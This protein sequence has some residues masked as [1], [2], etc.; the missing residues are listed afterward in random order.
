LTFA[1]HSSCCILPRRLYRFT[2]PL[3]CSFSNPSSSAIS[4][5]VIPASRIA[6][7]CVSIN[8]ICVYFL[9]DITLPPDVIILHQGAFCLLSDFTGSVH[10]PGGFFQASYH[11]IFSIFQVSLPVT[12]SLTFIPKICYTAI[13]KRDH[14]TEHG[15][16]DPPLFLSILFY[17]LNCNNTGISIAKSG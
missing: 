17:R 13:T 14:L 6:I 5:R 12:K 2:Q 15:S 9:F 4:C 16:T 8:L 1:G 10:F 7:I 11:T 3:I